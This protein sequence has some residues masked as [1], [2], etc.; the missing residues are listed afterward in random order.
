MAKIILITGGAR[1]GKS[2]F[3]LQKAEEL[4]GRHC[5]IATC[6]VLDKEMAER[7]D[8]HRKERSRH[9]W[10]T[11]EEPLSI[12]EVLSRGSHDV[13]LVDC[14]TLWINNH[15]ESCGRE[16]IDCNESFIG[17]AT[18]RVLTAIETVAATV[19]FVTNEVGLG[20]VPSNALARRYRDLVGQ[21]NRLVAAA[22]EEV[23]LI[24][25][26]LPIYLKK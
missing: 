3:A 22:A 1:S 21:C 17:D 24:S 11:V 23:V 18:E 5:F 14:L 4:K 2:S 9:I 6:P 16:K 8:K 12:A 10:D 15:L 13:Y 7:I 26:G 20:I 25:C 19:I